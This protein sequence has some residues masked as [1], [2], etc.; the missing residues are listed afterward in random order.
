MKVK[1]WVCLG[2]I[3]NLFVVFFGRN[4]KRGILQFIL[5]SSDKSRRHGIYTVPTG[6][7]S[8][9]EGGLSPD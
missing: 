6:L 7:Y 5:F 4:D 3:K 8:A 2:L 9:I 1:Y